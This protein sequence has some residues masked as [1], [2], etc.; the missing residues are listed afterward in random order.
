MKAKDDHK[1]EKKE[2]EV[3]EENKA[4]KGSCPA[5][6]PKV[7]LPPSLQPMKIWL[8]TGSGYWRKHKSFKQFIWA[9]QICQ[10]S[11]TDLARGIKMNERK[12]SALS[13]A[14]SLNILKLQ[15][16]F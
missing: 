1:E 13:K 2:P 11:T 15:A 4:S 8:H 9:L 12:Q 16:A 6:I 10:H 5:R 7:T 3:K 14:Q